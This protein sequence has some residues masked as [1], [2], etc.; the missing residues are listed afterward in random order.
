MWETL[1]LT[2]LFPP[3][4]IG[5]LVKSEISS[6]TLLMVLIIVPNTG[7]LG[8]SVLFGPSIKVYYLSLFLS[9]GQQICHSILRH[10]V[11]FTGPF[12]SLLHFKVNGLY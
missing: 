6:P 4:T 11:V 5:C 2:N 9:L 12:H 10:V 1:Y 7:R 8:K 3:L